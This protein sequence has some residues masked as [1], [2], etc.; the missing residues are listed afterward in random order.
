MEQ[1]QKVR[2]RCD[3]KV[4]LWIADTPSS[5]SPAETITRQALTPPPTPAEKITVKTATPPTTDNY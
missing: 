3:T 5:S 4:V 1:L 2:K